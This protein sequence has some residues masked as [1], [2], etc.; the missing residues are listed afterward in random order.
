MNKNPN[1]KQTPTA[2]SRRL[3]EL[4]KLL[5]SRENQ[6]EE[7]LHQNAQNIEVVWEI[8]NEQQSVLS[9]QQ[10]ELESLHNELAQQ[11]EVVLSLSKELSAE[12]TERAKLV[13]TMASLS[14]SVTTLINYLE[15]QTQ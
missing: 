9:E 5:K 7:A 11:S 8:F 12:Q 1:T 3:L 14:D 13:S 2:Q 4:E 6:T 15:G 10:K